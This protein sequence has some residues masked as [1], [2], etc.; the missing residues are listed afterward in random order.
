VAE[1][2]YREIDGVVQMTT[3][4]GI[5]LSG[6][7]NRRPIGPGET[8]KEVAVRLL[9]LKARKSPASPFNRPIGHRHYFN[10]GKI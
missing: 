1:A 7:Q 5:A 9:R 2:W 6:K 3:R 4:E 10:A 8:A